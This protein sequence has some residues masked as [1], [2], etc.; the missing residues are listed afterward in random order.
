MPASD[1]EMPWRIKLWIARNPV[2]AY[3]ANKAFEELLHRYVLPAVVDRRL[4]P[5][6]GGVK[7][8]LGTLFSNVPDQAVIRS[9]TKKQ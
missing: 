9:L 5:D 7:T 2:K 8:L 1:A 6:L 4:N 3:K